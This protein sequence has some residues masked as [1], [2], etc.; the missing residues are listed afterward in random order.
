MKTKVK[1]HTKKTKT[2]LV[3]V[4]EHDRNNQLTKLNDFIK[5]EKKHISKFYKEHKDKKINETVLA[6]HKTN[7]KQ[8]VADFTTSNFNINLD[9]QKH[10]SIATKIY[11][12]LD[13]INNKLFKPENII[14]LKNGN[15]VKKDL[16]KSNYKGFGYFG[17]GTKVDNLI[18]DYYD[19]KPGDTFYNQQIHIDKNWGET[20]KRKD[21]QTI[22]V[23]SD[24]KS[25]IHTIKNGQ[26]KTK[27]LYMNKKDIF[28]I[29]KRGLN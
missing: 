8:R 9:S 18:K 12:K 21:L 5:N 17:N 19:I 28:K 1:L 7:Q 6:S 13:N 2:G 14:K 4:K 3:F 29:I 15:I 26:L 16:S 23:L 27:E 22:Q 25:L 20:L 10:K 24:N 11:T